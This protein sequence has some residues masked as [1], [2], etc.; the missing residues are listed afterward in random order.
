LLEK[1]KE[2]STALS[3]ISEDGS[4]STADSNAQK[5]NNIRKSLTYIAY[6]WR[7]PQSRSNH[8]SQQS[9]SNRMQWGLNTTCP[10]KLVELANA[11][12]GQTVVRT[13][14][15][16]IDLKRSQHCEGQIRTRGGDD[17][18]HSQQ[19]ESDSYDSEQL[20]DGFRT[21]VE[22]LPEGPKIRSDAAVE[23]PKTAAG[24][25]H[26]QSDHDSCEECSQSDNEDD[27]DEDSTSRNGEHEEGDVL[28]RYLR[29]ADCD[30]GT[31]G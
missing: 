10:E 3:T 11:A 9:V 6:G 20:S 7:E 12:L 25:Q 8:Y 28:N 13:T 30:W 26:T 15:Q 21:A 4:V 29:P 14:L 22:S 19:H 18:G 24:R 2:N 1:H 31:N 27:N 17:A 16:L 5:L 23:E